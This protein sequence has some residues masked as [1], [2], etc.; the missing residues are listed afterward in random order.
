MKL[1]RNINPDGGG[2]YAVVNMRMYREALDPTGAIQK[3]FAVLQDAGI[4]DLGMVGTHTEFFLVKLK[5]RHSRPALLA[6]ERSIEPTDP[7]FALEVATMAARSGKL[8][9]WC[10]E[11]D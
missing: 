10:Q 3:A 5:D 1:D 4:I 2:K 11:P 6:Y 9:P 7:E 8:S